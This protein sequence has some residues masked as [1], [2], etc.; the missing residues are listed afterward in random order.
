[1]KTVQNINLK[2]NTKLSNKK[3]SNVLFT[4]DNIVNLK[5]IHCEFDNCRLLLKNV[6]N[7]S[8]TNNKISFP[9]LVDN[10]PKYVNSKGEQAKY[11]RG[12]ELLNVILLKFKIMNY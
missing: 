1:M 6:K 4:A 7:L 11:A 9:F 10:D 3:Y 12:M 5:M 2:S 8:F